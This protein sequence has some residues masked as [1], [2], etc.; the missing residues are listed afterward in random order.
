MYS[1]S[2]STYPRQLCLD[3]EADVSRLSYI[4]G[5][6]RPSYLKGY[7]TGQDLFMDVPLKRLLWTSVLSERDRPLFRRGGWF[8]ATA[9]HF[10]C[11][12]NEI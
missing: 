9:T 7:Y 6:L 4:A 12:I 5:L 2:W 11:L 8:D 1:S 10:F 3:G